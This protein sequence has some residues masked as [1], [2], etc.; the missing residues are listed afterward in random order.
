MVLLDAYIDGPVAW[1]LLKALPGAPVASMK[2]PL[3]GP[4]RLEGFK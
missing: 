1:Y 2:I 3:D 4:K